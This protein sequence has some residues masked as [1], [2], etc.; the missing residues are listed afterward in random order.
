MELINELYYDARPNKSQ[1]N[2]LCNVASCWIRNGICTYNL[3][4]SECEAHALYIVV[5]G[6]SNSP[7]TPHYLINTT[8][9]GKK[10]PLLNVECVFFLCNAGLI[11]LL[12]LLPLTLQPAVGFGLSNNTSPFFP[13]Y[14]QLSPSCHSQHLKI[15]F[16]YC[17]FCTEQLKTLCT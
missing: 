4:Y 10:K 16:Y 14:H 7:I 17:W 2:K 13:I 9:F 3:P 5:C 6:L 1:D 11:L 15:S 8:M 12:L